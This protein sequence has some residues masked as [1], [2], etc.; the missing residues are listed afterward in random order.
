[1]PNTKKSKNTRK[2]KRKYGVIR[3]KRF[4]RRDPLVGQWADMA[5]SC[6]MVDPDLYV[7][8]DVKRSL[9]D[10]SGKGVMAGLT[11]IG[12][13][14]AEKTGQDNA[15]IKEGQLLYRG[16][17]I[18][19]LIEGF[20]S[21]NRLGF[22]ETAYLLLFGKLPNEEELADFNSSLAKYRVLPHGFVRDAILNLPSPDIMNSMSR[23][24]LALYAIV[25]TPDDISIEN[26][27]RQ[28]MQLIATLPMLAVYSYQ[29]CS[30]AYSGHSMVIHPPRLDLSTAG[31]ILHMLRVDSSYTKLEEQLL[32]LLLVLHAEHGGGNNSTFVA[33]VASSSATDTYATI[34]AALGSLKG[35]RHGGANMKVQQMFKDIKQNV[36]NW[37][38]DD[39]ISAYLSRILEK[40]A[41]DK[42]GLIYGMGHAVYSH[43]DPRTTILKKHALAL[44]QEKGRLD[45]F[46]L[47]ERIERL[48]PAEIAKVRKI[49]KGVSANVDIYSGFVYDLLG[50]PSELFTPLFAIARVVG[51]CAHR[52]EEVAN[53]GKIIRP[54]YKSVAELT[55][56]TPMDKR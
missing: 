17:D 21:G 31:N 42:S 11:R 36:T 41:F 48:A 52:I 15:V 50:I 28:S 30:R 2:G 13:V 44:S 43:S 14:A 53:G 27:L 51:W 45:E 33:R 35:P 20:T 3:K 16:I 32:D 22:E 56:Y 24:V 19:E 54:A 8:Y 18:E 46:K 10:I 37:E 47:Y 9:R 29:V 49:Y 7:K 55:G 6:S 40:E 25:P 38:D 12:S 26:I 4:H 34:S 1:M 39:E 23:S 5:K